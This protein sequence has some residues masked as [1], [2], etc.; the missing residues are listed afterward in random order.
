MIYVCYRIDNYHGDEHF[1]HIG[2]IEVAFTEESKAQEWV[3]FKN[4]SLRSSG[5]DISE[6]YAYCGIELLEEGS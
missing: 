3:E 1:P 6:E 4:S 2:A 5:I